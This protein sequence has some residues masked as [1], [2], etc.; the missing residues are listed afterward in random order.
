[1]NRNQVA[2]ATLTATEAMNLL[3]NYSVVLD[4]YSQRA[5]YPWQISQV[6]WRHQDQSDFGIRDVV[7]NPPELAQPV[8]GR[9]PYDAAIKMSPSRRDPYLD[10]PV[11]AGHGIGSYYRGGG[12]GL[13]PEVGSMIITLR[14]AKHN[15]GY[16]FR[17]AR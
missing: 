2:A 13:P 4:E 1:M 3:R 11:V 14:K 10:T 15:I 9:K 7:M 8:W 12:Q 5:W 16:G 6:G 17:C